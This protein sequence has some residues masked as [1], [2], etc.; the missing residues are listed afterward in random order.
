MKRI[1]I[2]VVSALARLGAGT[3]SGR[4]RCRDTHRR[5]GNVR[6][7]A[8]I[9]VRGVS[10][11]VASRVASH[12]QGLYPPTHFRQSAY[13]WVC[14]KEQ[15]Q[16]PHYIDPILQMTCRPVRHPGIVVA[17]WIGS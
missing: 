10:C 4:T 1:F 2:V 8:L 12:L 16:P 14:A 6:G 11:D 15:R 7:I 9:E 17:A 13:N 5:T 3:A